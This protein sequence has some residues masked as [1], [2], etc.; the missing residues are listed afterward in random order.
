MEVD[1]SIEG[2]GEPVVLIHGGASNN[3]QW[4][5]LTQLLKGRFRVIAP[6]LHGAGKTPPWGTGRPYR[7]AEGA[8]II[9]R[10]CERAGNSLNLV[11]HSYGGAVALQA[12]AQL[13]GRVAR[14]VLLEAAPYDLLRQAGRHEAYQAAR[15]L[16]EFVLDGSAKGE[17]RAIAER[18]LDAFAGAG[19]WQAMS[20]ERRAR[21]AD[22]MRQNRFEWEALMAADTPLEEWARRTP[23]RTLL[24]SAADTWP[25]LR[26][27]MELFHA[28]CPAWTFALLPEGGHL[29]PLTRPELVNPIIQDFLMDRRIQWTKGR[30]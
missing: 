18:F 14:L 12:A 22:L 10:A 25:P 15:A 23:E 29:A 5:A 19:A 7:L 3:R 20:E 16:Y 24:V 6:N 11:G 28:G 2:E 13:G 4:K 27:V 8:A 9:E 1:V 30:A 17:W 26:E 21:A